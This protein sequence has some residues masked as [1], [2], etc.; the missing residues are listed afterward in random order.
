MLGIRLALTALILS[1]GTASA[2]AETIIS[3]SYSYYPV[4]GQT[5]QKLEEELWRGGPELAETGNRHPGATRIRISREISFE[6]S[7]NRCAVGDVKVK[8]DTLLTLP[9]WTDSSGADRKARLVWRTLSSDIKRHE[10]RHAEIARQWS[11]KLESALRNLRPEADCIR[12]QAKVEATSK[13]I[14]EKHAADHERFD[15]VEAASFER[16]IG[17]ILR[18]KAKQM[19]TRD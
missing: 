4:G 15:R 19:E 9:R 5:A 14:L 18:Y 8:L 16:R 3:K 10:E 2:G 1:L 11:R 13:S 7:R 12:M 6:Q 17:R